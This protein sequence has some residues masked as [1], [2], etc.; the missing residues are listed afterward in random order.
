M[1]L[2]EFIKIFNFQKPNPE[3]S[4]SASDRGASWSDLP[5]G[6]PDCDLEG[7][8]SDEIAKFNAIKSLWEINQSKKPKAGS[9]VWKST[10]GYIYLVG[11]SNASL[12]RILGRRFTETLPV[13]ER[14]LKAQLDDA[15]RSVVANIEEGFARP[16]TSEYLQFLGY[17]QASLKEVKGDFQRSRQDSFLRSVRGSSLMD[18]KIDLK[19]WHQVLIQSVISHPP[20]SPGDS[21]SGGRGNIPWGPLS[22]SKKTKGDYRKLKDIKGRG[23]RFRFGYTP[24]D[25]MKAGSLTYEIFIELVN[26]TDWHLRRLVESLEEKLGQERKSYQ[27]EKSRLKGKLK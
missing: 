26:K 17:S 5:E 21:A 24:V 22:S 19:G 10:N 27:V 15:M 13:S 20:A 18:I 8:S 7:L 1:T 6:F 3:K 14:R 12:L 11:W 25:E 16:T 2:K 23:R 9:R 4:D